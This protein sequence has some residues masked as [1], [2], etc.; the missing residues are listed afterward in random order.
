MIL[1][2]NAKLFSPTY[3]RKLSI[4]A[5]KNVFNH[6]H[7]QHYAEMI[8]EGHIFSDVIWGLGVEPQTDHSFFLVRGHVR[9][10]K[11]DGGD[12]VENNPFT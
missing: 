10:I 6:K 11:I 2:A 7:H 9:F 8:A 3:I 4:F 12:G 1:F 5:P